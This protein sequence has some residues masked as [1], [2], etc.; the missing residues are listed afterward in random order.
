MKNKNSKL[1]S[2]QDILY[3][4]IIIMNAL[5]FKQHLILYLVCV[6]LIKLLLTA[7]TRIPDFIVNNF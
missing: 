4:W 7:T 1:Q 5:L 3:N 2:G 6:E